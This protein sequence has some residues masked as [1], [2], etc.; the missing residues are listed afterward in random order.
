MMILAID[1]SLTSV[2]ACVFNG[3]TLAMLAEESIAMDR[4]HAEALLPLIDR[5]VSRVDGEFSVLD[6]VA[7]TV[8]PGSF[9]GIRVGIAAAQGVA[10]ALEIP[11]V[12]V[13]TLAAFAA[14]PV[15][16]GGT[17]VIVSA[18]DARHDQV[19]FQTYDPAGRT[20]F[21]PRIARTRDAAGMIGKGPFR[22]TGSAGSIMVIEAWT[23]LLRA[24]PAGALI[25]PPIESVARL[26]LSAQ[27]AFAPATPL[28][29]KDADVTYAPTS[30][31]APAR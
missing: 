20:I 7:V 13:S 10:L 2:S 16:D 18:I 21:P 31:F 1:T 15:L 14:E 5:V 6:R 11:V 26:G 27:P 4:G 9:T 28:Y 19:Y 12:G 8:G 24:E 23:L 30:T 25:D 22:M 17:S 3:R 29:L